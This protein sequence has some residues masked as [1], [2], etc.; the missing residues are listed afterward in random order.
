MTEPAGAGAHPSPEQPAPKPL[1]GPEIDLLVERYKREM[2]RYEEVSLQ[3]EQRLRRAFR[4]GTVRAL[5]SSR[6]KHPDDLQ[7][8]LELRTRR[9]DPRYTY[10]QLADGFNRIV[11]D[12][13]GCRVLV[14]RPT[15]I[16]HAARIVLETF[17]NQPA[18]EGRTEKHDRESG[19]RADHILVELG[20]DE[21]RGSLRGAICEVQI[22]SLGAHLFNELEH[23]IVYKDHD[24]PPTEAERVALANLLHA[25]RLSDAMAEQVVEQRA[26]AVRKQSVPLRNAEELKL[27]L[28]TSVGRPM[29]GE[30]MRLFRLLNT[31]VNPLTAAFVESQEPGRL[32][33]AGAARAA[34]LHLTAVDDVVSLAL[35]LFDDFGTEFASIVRGQKGPTT[36]LKKAILEAEKVR[37]T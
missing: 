5:L 3:V 17:P 18:V 28:E 6:A 35:A 32:L 27:V 7:K 4:A 36:P 10:V 9:A 30:F 34:E 31:V 33:A 11:T 25:A 2:T 21:E 1:T 23:D 26:V 22:A 14:Y 8:K 37:T 29:H 12:L 24:V 15:D 13:A 16:Q 19:Y 20:D